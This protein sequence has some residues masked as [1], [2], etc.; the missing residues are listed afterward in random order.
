M[1]RPRPAAERLKLTLEYDGSGFSGWQKQKHARTVQG[2]LIEAIQQVLASQ[3]G[4]RY[5][6]LQGAGRTDAGVHAF[7][8]VAH[9]DCET[10][11]SPRALKNLLN[12]ALPPEIYLHRVEP[13][14]KTFHARH[15]A[16]AR[17]YLY[18]IGKR[19]N[20]FERNLLY[21]PQQ[22]FDLP[23]M[24]QAAGLLLGMH[25]F[26]SFS[27]RPEQEKSPQ[28]L[29]QAIELIDEDEVL[30]IRVRASH[31][32]WSMVRILTGALLEAG[33][34]KLSPAQLQAALQIYDPQLKHHKLP[35][36]GLFLEEVVY[37]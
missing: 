30:M 31:F 2:C 21:V 36:S 18:R 22:S 17:Q 16:R 12:E 28:V 13:V 14:D 26:S 37:D 32:L 25:D 11:L 4:G 15:S 1:S 19:R 3:G 20:V 9:L 34:G 24:E 29:L 5:H 33:K 8:Q 7:A 23:L 6:D 35:A 27:S 10:R